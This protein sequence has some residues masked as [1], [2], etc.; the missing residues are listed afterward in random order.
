MRVELERARAEGG[1]PSF[2]RLR[3]L[4]LH[5]KAQLRDS[6]CLSNLTSTGGLALFASGALLFFGQFAIG[7]SSHRIKVQLHFTPR[8]PIELPA[9]LTCTRFSLARGLGVRLRKNILSAYL[10]PLCRRR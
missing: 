9:L 10:S 8:A 4:R 5:L 7:L 2:C 6:D 1:A 3:S